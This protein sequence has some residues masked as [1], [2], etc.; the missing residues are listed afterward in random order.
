MSLEQS[1]IADAFEFLGYLLDK[2]ENADNELKVRLDLAALKGRWQS[3]ITGNA[4]DSLREHSKKIREYGS[5]QEATP[6]YAAGSSR[7]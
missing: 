7:A 6:R 2:S 1:L 3:G 4:K 5:P